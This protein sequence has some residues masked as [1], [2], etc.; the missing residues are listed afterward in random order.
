MAT[1]GQFRAPV[2]GLEAFEPTAEVTEAHESVAE[3]PEELA[4]DAAVDSGDSFEDG[5]I[6]AQW[7]DT[8]ELV[9]RVLTPRSVTPRSVTPRFITPIDSVSFDDTVGAFGPEA[10]DYPVV[11]PDEAVELPWLAVSGSGQSS[12]GSTQAD[13]NNSADAELQA[14]ANAFAEDAYA[15]GDDD[16]LMATEEESIP[17]GQDESFADFTTELFP[18]S[19]SAIEGRGPLETATPFTLLSNEEEPSEPEAPAFVT[20]TMGELL[21]SQGLVSRAADVYEELVRRRPYDPVLATRLAELRQMLP[22]ADVPAAPETHEAVPAFSPVI[23]E[24]F[25]IDVETTFVSELESPLASELDTVFSSVRERDA[26]PLANDDAPT[27]APTPVYGT[28]VFAMPRVT[29]HAALHLTPPLAPYAQ[30]ATAEATRSARSARDWFAAIAAHRV[31]RRTPSQS[32]IA[33]ENSSEGLAA[34]FGN[35]ASAQDDAAARS[36][37]D[38]FA[39]MSPGE[40]DAGEGLDFDF[41]RATP[42]FT[43]SV[44]PPPPSPRITPVM[45]AGFSFDRFFPDPATQQPTPPPASIVLPDA[46]VTEDLAQ[47]SSWLKGL[48]NT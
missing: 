18:E 19:P 42:A 7:P 25:A 2:E 24:T 34:L 5:L 20:E 40:L 30:P 32:I 31:A 8:S 15:A 33:V 47:F 16:T 12:I 11:S 27:I 29:P 13:A 9:A 14:I 46:P 21:V 37:A 38:A 10:V 28:P 4:P 6:A 17:F 45:N 44:A 22:P 26:E 35:D 39:P 36:L 3:Q 1:V 23:E 41:A 48:G 43:A